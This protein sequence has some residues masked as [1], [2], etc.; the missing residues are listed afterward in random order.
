MDRFEEWYGAPYMVVYR[1]DLHRILME[2]LMERQQKGA[3]VE[4]EVRLGTRVV[5]YGVDEGWVQVQGGERLEADL[6]I[7][8]DG[9]NSSARGEL[10]RRLG[11][12]QQEWVVR[13]DM[14]AYRVMADVEQVRAD[15]LTRDIVEEHAGN[16]WYVTKN[17]R[18]RIH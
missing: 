1:A 15:V 14:A 18:K 13:T 3:A 2:A 10:M 9:I 4:V 5:E 7:A 11:A 17:K 8:C 16:C 12:Q 6:V